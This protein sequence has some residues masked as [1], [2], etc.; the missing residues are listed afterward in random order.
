MNYCFSVVIV[1]ITINVNNIAITVTTTTTITTTIIITIVIIIDLRVVA[2]L[3]IIIIVVVV[4]LVLSIIIPG[5]HTITVF[6]IITTLDQCEDEKYAVMAVMIVP[7]CFRA[8][9]DG[10][11]DR[12]DG[13]V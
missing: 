7:A 12:S 4:S 3:I 10:G 1:S 5:I 8:A 13:A 2:V 11:R 6:V 9:A